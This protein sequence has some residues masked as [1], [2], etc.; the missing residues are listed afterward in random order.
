[1]K[2]VYTLGLGILFC[3]PLMG[4]SK[5]MGRT[6]PTHRSQTFMAILIHPMHF[7]RSGVP[8]FLNL[9]RSGSGRSGRPGQTATARHCGYITA[10]TGTR[11]NGAGLSGA[12]NII[13]TAVSPITADQSFLIVGT[14]STALT[15]TTSNLPAA[16][17]SRLIR[18]WKVA[19]THSVGP[20]NL[21]FDFTGLTVTGAIGTPGDFRLMVN[22]AGD[23]TFATGTTNF[24]KPS[25]TS[26]VATF[27][28]VTLPDQAVF[29]IISNVA[30]GSPLPV[31]FV[32]FTAQASG[33]NVD[34]NWVVGDNSQASTYEINQSTDGVH[35]TSIGEVGNEA[36]QQAY[37]FVQTD[38]GPGQHYYQLLETDLDGKTMYSN[39]VSATIAAGDFSVAVLNNPA[40]GNTDAQLQIN[41]MTPGTALIELWS[42][43]GARISLQ[44]QAIGAGVNTVSIPVSKLPSGSYVVKVQV[45]N[46]VHVSQL[47]KL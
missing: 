14:D 39:I 4:T 42:V 24:Y 38:A 21:S 7:L 16:G 8:M 3:L 18:N 1:M 9:R 31:N 20:V 22:P 30:D 33:N 5:W 36:D 25:F 2:K 11:G 10:N 35:F 46:N 28:N 17:G 12:G 15:E 32:S 40:A 44:Q 27:N 41:T 43:G 6:A 29:G 26:N 47:I 37:S 34:L 45:N 23:P 13:L 19:N